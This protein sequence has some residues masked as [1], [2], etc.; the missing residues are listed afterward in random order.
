MLLP[1]RATLLALSSALLFSAAAPAGRV[2]LADLPPLSLAGLLYLGAALGVLPAALRG[3]TSAGQGDDPVPDVR[4]SR[5]H[6]A[7]AIVAGGVVA[8]VLLLLALERE[9]ASTVSLFLNLELAATA[10]LGVAFFGEHLHRQGWL[11]VGGAVAAGALL[12]T[13]GGWPGVSA[14][15]L[16]VGACVCWGLD[17]Q[18]TALVDGVSPAESTLWK[19]L[20][21]GGTNLLLGV[22]LEPSRLA[23][24]PVIAALGVGALSY[25]VSIA[26]HIAASQD[27]GATRAQAIFASAPFFGAALSVAALGESF[28]LRHA[29]ASVAFALSVALVL[30]DR[31]DHLHAHRGIEHTHNH[32]HDDGHHL[33]THPGAKPWLRHSHWHRH[34]PL[35]HAH[36][37]RPDL[38]HRHDH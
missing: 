20:I 33:H 6:L 36:P 16:L 28:G 21:A 17:N 19:G 22:A 37:H 10:L 30:R 26:L 27:L 3:R 23:P 15:A 25:G 29:A 2:L 14:A 24:F 35:A 13:G 32:R 31:H 34:E 38:H 9:S 11:G 4:A 18:W 12:A 7:G 1:R 8:P 5:R